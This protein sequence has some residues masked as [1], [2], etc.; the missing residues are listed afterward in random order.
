MR[1]KKNLVP[2]LFVLVFFLSNTSLKVYAVEKAQNYTDYFP[3][4][5][6]EAFKS[7]S[8]I[9][10]NSSIFT[11]AF[12]P[13]DGITTY[14]DFFKVTVA[15]GHIIT[16]KPGTPKRDGYIFKGWYGF[17]D[18]YD[19]PVLWN[20][21]TDTVEEN[22]TLWAFWEKAC[23]IVFDPDD[24]IT[25]YEDFYKITV[26]TGRLI[27]TTPNAPKRE[28]Y[29]FKGWYSYLDNNYK[30]VLWNFATDTVEENTILWAAWI[31]NTET[32]NGDEENENS[33][34]NN[35]NEIPQKGGGSSSGS[36]KKKGGTIS[37]EI[38]NRGEDVTVLEEP[39]L[40][41]NESTSSLGE[42]PIVTNQLDTMP[43]TGSI[44]ILKYGI[45]MSLSLLLLPVLLF[46]REKKDET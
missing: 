45:N 11:V 32:G 2:V 38:I 16:T 43:K 41:T 42:S 22:T 6:S 33:N 18:D 9:P 7:V 24:G 13:D 36:S 27:S 19:K 39:P 17:L 34:N 12:D 3:A 8:S 26:P 21:S 10:Q 20:F 14:E 4:T 30:P 28:D 31:Q 5:P 23:L 25:T 37:V 44:D 35:E 15:Q 1:K 40:I 46:H 29:I